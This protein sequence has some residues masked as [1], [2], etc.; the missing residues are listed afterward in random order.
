MESKAVYPTQH[1]RIHTTIDW[2]VRP[3]D[4]GRTVRQQKRN[5]WRDIARL[6]R[7]VHG[8]HILLGASPERRDEVLQDGRVA[9][10]GLTAFIRMPRERQAQRFC[11]V[12]TIS[13]SFEK[14]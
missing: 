3:P 4:P 1:V 6:P 13:A 5:H 7:P 8:L 2:H 14:K 9:G 12:H 11:I 10:P